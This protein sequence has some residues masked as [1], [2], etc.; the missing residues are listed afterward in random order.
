MSRRIRRGRRTLAHL[1][2]ITQAKPD[3]AKEPAKT[4]KKTTAKKAT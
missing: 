1:D 3:R 4:E 2:A